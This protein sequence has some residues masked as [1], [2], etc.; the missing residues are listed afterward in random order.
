MEQK[1]AGYVQGD[2]VRFQTGCFI[3]RVVALESFRKGYRFCTGC[4]DSG[5]FRVWDYKLAL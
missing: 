1:A 2:G 4:V 3:L 5:G